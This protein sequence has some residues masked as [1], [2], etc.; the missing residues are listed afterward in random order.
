MKHANIFD[1]VRVFYANT[2]RQ[3]TLNLTRRLCHRT[4]QNPIG[5]IASLDAV[6][7]NPGLSALPKSFI[8]RCSR[9]ATD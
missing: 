9:L 7:R 1:D 5:W 6:K 3:A 8:S 4:I 2:F